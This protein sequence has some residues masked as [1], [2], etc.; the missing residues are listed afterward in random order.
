MFKSFPCFNLTDL[1]KK[2]LIL[3]GSLIALI[4]LVFA[5]FIFP[6]IQTKK[7][8]DYL[9]HI[10]NKSPEIERQIYF[11][12][13]EIGVNLNFIEVFDGNAIIDFTTKENTIDSF[14]DEVV[15]VMYIVLEKYQE[16]KQITVRVA[17]NKTDS[18][19]KKDIICVVFA[20]AEDIAQVKVKHRQP[21]DVDIVKSFET[22]LDSSLLK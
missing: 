18:G 8:D 5:L 7:G 6:G 3:A 20:D 11:Q 22:W 13:V 2:H 10:A 1:P 4:V 19:E 21:E 14:N 9:R 12:A 15:H 16:L 17:G